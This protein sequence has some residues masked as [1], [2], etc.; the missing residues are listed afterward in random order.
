[1]SL[2]ELGRAVADM[3][4]AR[5]AALTAGLEPE[6][7]DV[8]E[9]AIAAAEAE[10]DISAEA[11]E[12]ARAHE[13]AAGRYARWWSD[14]AAFAAEA[15]TWP[16][17]QAL[18]GYQ[19]EALR[20][21][22]THQRLV[23]R[24][25]HGVGGTAVAAIAVLWFALTRDYYGVNWRVITT[26]SVDRQLSEYLW[27]EVHRWVPALRWEQLA[28]APWLKGRELLQGHIKLAHGRALG[29]TAADPAKIEGAHADQLLV[30]ADEAKAIDAAVF[31]A[32]EGAFASAGVETGRAAYALALST[33]GVASG[34]FYDLCRGAPGLEDWARQHVTLEQ[35]V[36]AGQVSAT[37]AEARRR[38]WGAGST[39]YRTRV[40]GEFADDSADT[41]I[42]LSW[43]EAAN[44]RWL[45]LSA[46][47]R[48][49]PTEYAGIDVARGG[50]DRSV[51]V[52]MAGDVVGRPVELPR[53]D[54]PT[55]AAG[56]LGHVGTGPAGPWVLVDVA[57]VGAAV[58]DPL[59]RAR[60]LGPRVLPFDAGS[61]TDW[62]DTSGQLRFANLRAAAWWHLREMLDPALDAT[63]ALP[64]G[65]ALTGDLTTPRWRDSTKGILIESKDDIRK[66]L[67]RS[68]DD[69][70]ALVMAAWGRIL[71][72]RS[73][74]RPSTATPPAGAG[75]IMG[76][77]LNEAL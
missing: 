31:D 77:I 51:L 50:A 9:A 46:A 70:D 3:G 49:V 64:P 1:M 15:L 40:L 62:R 69:G 7:L 61:R 12:A 74:L 45:A 60:D 6:D 8:L 20:T 26:A 71:V 59:R 57:G 36:A 33:P 66:R 29:A 68:T 44:E 24:K 39:L 67:G 28:R 38:Q 30:I 35:A 18:H 4:D 41:V 27:P 37:W 34:R 75:S 16:S 55:T 52:A 22:A 72:A 13:S 11:A 2:A 54:G 76:D 56:A 48:A 63:L 47:Q 43:V 21:L 58:Y 23:L 17:G 19:A 5:Y 32:L 10:A 25:L 73:R 53:G 14:P 65:D 42:P